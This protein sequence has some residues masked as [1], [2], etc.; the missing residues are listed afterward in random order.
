MS[1]TPDPPPSHVTVGYVF[2]SEDGRRL[3]VLP[4]Q[5]LQNL[6]HHF[7]GL[8]CEGRVHALHPQWRNNF[9][10]I[11]YTYVDAPDIRPDNPA[12]F[13]IRYPAGYPANA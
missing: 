9:I 4:Q 12:F 11:F 8:Q 10:H 2:G 3:G 7:T 13:N 1:G 5:P 6:V